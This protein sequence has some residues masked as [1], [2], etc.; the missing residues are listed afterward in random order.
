MEKL[1]DIVREKYKKLTRMLI[2]RRVSVTTMESCTSGLVASLLTDTEG[3]SAIMKGAF[4][5]YSNEAKIRQGVSEQVIRDHGVYSSETAVAM[6]QACRRIY[7]ADIGIGVTGSF[8][9][10]DPNNQDSIPGE[11]F[12]S[13]DTKTGTETY[14]CTVPEQPD[15]LA[16]KLFVAN[17]IADKLLLIS[18]E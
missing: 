18:R 11:V 4:I 7:D 6:A 17:E 12:F 3:S 15:R 16:Y 13:I 8:G 14:H 10:K 9:N 2:S 1:A 5:T